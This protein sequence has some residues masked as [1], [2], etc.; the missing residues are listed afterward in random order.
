MIRFLLAV[1][2]SIVVMSS[3]C[4]SRDKRAEIGSSKEIIP[5]AIFFDYQVT[6]EEDNDSITVL[7]QFR[8]W[9]EFGAT[10]ALDTPGRVQFDGELIKGDSTK[11]TGAFYEIRKPLKTFNG[12]HNIVFTYDAGKQYREEFIFQLLKLAADIP[13]TLRRDSLDLSLLGLDS[14]DVVRVVMTD[15]VFGSEGI[16]R[17][18][19]V[20]DGH[21]II[22]PKELKT[23]ADGPIQLHLVKESETPVKNRSRKLGRLYMIYRLK[24]EFLLTQ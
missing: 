18:D 15:T 3:S 5:E 17:L 1:L 6:G 4:R 11:I 19:T 10:L 12:P 24:R 7:L 16:D 9:G 21:I 20:K 22:T 23:L 2:L 8:S 13:A 14:G